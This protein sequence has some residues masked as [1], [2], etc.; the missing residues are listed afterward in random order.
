MQLLLIRHGKAGDREA[1]RQAGKDDFDRPLTPAGRKQMKAAA[2]GLRQIIPKIDILAT[3]PLVR[4][5]QTAEL[6]Y[7]AY[8]DRPEFVEKDILSGEHPA[9]K[10]AH[11][12]KSLNKSDGV[13]A[14]VGHEPDLSHYAGYFIAGEEEEI[15]EMKKGGVCVIEFQ[16]QIG[17]GRGKLRS[18]CSAK[19][20]RRMARR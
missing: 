3:S 9:A 7:A 18:L 17:M 15:I 13:V 10:L 11:W 2:K 14:C 4:A 12:L 6:V 5:R 8:Q 19:D 16:R 1:W 20:L